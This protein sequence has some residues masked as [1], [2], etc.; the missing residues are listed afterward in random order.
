MRTHMHRNAMP[1]N[2]PKPHPKAVLLICLAVFLTAAPGSGAAESLPVPVLS[3]AGIP[4]YGCKLDAAWAH[5]PAAFTQ[6]LAYHNGYLYESTGLRGASSLRKIDVVTGRVLKLHRLPPSYFAEGMTILN[7]KIYQLTWTAGKCFVYGLERFDVQNEFSYQGQG[8][9][10]AHDGQRLIM[11]DGSHRLRF[12]DPAT[13]TTEEVV[14][15]LLNGRP[16]KRL[17]EL[18]YVRGEVYANIWQTHSIARIDPLSGKVLGLIDVSG[19]A[20]RFSPIRR[21]DVANGIAYDNIG[22]RLFITGKLWPKL[23]HVTL[24]PLMAA[25]NET[26]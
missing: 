1:P 22:D 17:N 5:D 16:L 20:A 23:F 11:S 7:G 21:V 12:I 15:V 6:G 13:F 8:W 24:T 19:L 25:G 26:R 9:G 10:L 18:E 4:A 3:A 14:E 2:H